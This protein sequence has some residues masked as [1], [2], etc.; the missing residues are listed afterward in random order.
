MH[1]SPQKMPSFTYLLLSWF[2]K[3]QLHFN[4]FVFPFILDWYIFPTEAF[5]DPV[6]IYLPVCRIEKYAGQTAMYSLSCLELHFLKVDTV[7]QLSHC[8]SYCGLPPSHAQRLWGCVCE[9]LA[10]PDYPACVPLEQTG[11]GTA[12]GTVKV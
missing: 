11:G 3:L 10:V 6:P 12:T 5:R 2:S 8:L 1:Q 9:G 4:E 7:I